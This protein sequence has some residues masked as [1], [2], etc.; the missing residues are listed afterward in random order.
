M[1]CFFVFV[2]LIGV[3][4]VF[5]CEICLDFV[6]LLYLQHFQ[7]WI[8]YLILFLAFNSCLNHANICLVPQSILCIHR[9]DSL[10]LCPHCC[11]SV[12]FFP[13]GI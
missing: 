11:L 1:F 8:G 3:L 4:E 10:I 6:S 7:C 2:S 9:T 5:T 12:F 13:G